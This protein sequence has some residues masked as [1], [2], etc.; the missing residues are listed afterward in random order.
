MTPPCA[1]TDV[2]DVTASSV[3]AASTTAI[4]PIFLMAFLLYDREGASGMTSAFF[5]RGVPLAPAHPTAD[6]AV[7]C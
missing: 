2:T 5:A 3:T 7:I 4:E 6:R 1:K